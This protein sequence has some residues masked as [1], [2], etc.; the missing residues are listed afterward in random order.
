MAEQDALSKFDFDQISKPG[1]FL[2]FQA[3]K[4]VTLRVLTTNPVIQQQ[5]F[6]DSD[7]GEISLSNKFCFIVYN[8]TDGKAQILSATPAMARKIGELHVD[9][10]FGAN[11]RN[12]DIKISPTGEK[13]ERRY[14]IQVLPQPKEL[15]NAMVKEA[16]GIDLDEVVDKGSRMSIWEKPKEPGVA[17]GSSGSEPATGHDQAAAQA[18]K[19][20]P[21]PAP[22]PDDVVIQDIGDE[23]INLDDIP[24]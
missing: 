16:Q 23:P 9:P 18:N 19:L 8:F 5:E 22:A 24:F 3:G 17:V 11:I 13:L 15:T 4:P 20:R 12:I 1:M 14:D 21:A 7:T 10:D 6:K 2:K